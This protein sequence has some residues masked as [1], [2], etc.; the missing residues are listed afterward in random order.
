MI[1]SRLTGDFIFKNL[2]AVVAASAIVI[3][4]ITG[5][6][7]STGAVPAVQKFGSNFFFGSAWNPVEGRE[8]YG[9]LPY[10]MGTLVTSGI[11]LVVGVPLSLGIAVFLAEIAPR[12][13]RVP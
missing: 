9:A 10:V 11:A 4:F 13:L 12:T 1:K 3:L 8:I 2:A 6:V 7:L 5:Y